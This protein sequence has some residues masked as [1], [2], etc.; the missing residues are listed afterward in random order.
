MS[1]ATSPIPTLFA[2]LRE[3]LAAIDAEQHTEGNYL[4]Y[5][6]TAPKFFA[7]IVQQL[8]AAGLSTARERTLAARRHREA[9]RARS[10]V[11][12]GAEPRDQERAAGKSDLPHRSLPGQRDR[13]EHHGLPLRQRHLRAHLEPALHRS[14][15]DHECRNGRRGAARRLLR[16]CRNPARHGSQPCDATA[17]PD[18]DGI[19]GIFSG[20]RGPQRAGQSS[21]LDSAAEFRRRAA[22]Q[23]ARPIW[24]RASMRRTRGA[25][26]SHRARRLS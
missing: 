12:Q 13:A 11:G 24:R 10:R 4:F 3:R 8:G 2:N 17:Q 9:L 16:Q 22:A 25:A 5:L 26:L 14:R 6:A 21:A 18:R 19:A 23:R 7:P 1:A 20:R 15:A